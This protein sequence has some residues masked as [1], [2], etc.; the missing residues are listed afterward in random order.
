MKNTLIAVAVAAL[1]CGSTA[2]AQTYNTN[3]IYTVNQ[4]IPDGDFSG[5]ALST[6]LTGMSGTVSDLT[7]GLNILGGNNADLYAYLAGPNGGFAVLLNRVGVDLANPYGYEDSGFSITLGSAAASNVHHYQA[8]GFTLNGND[9]LT[10]FWAPDG[11]NI[12][13][14]SPPATFDTAPVTATL[15]SFVGTNPNGLWTFYIADVSGGASGILESWELSLT[16]VPEPSTLAL[17]IVGGLLLGGVF[18]RRKQVKAIN[19]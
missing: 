19:Q 6:N 8:T 12:S 18:R 15:D 17:A 1:T 7:L 4:V 13:P 14:L 16:T 3:L 5:L 10:G 9:Q 2:S 11:R